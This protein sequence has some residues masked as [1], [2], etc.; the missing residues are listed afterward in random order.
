MKAKRIRGGI[1]VKSC[2]R[3][4]GKKKKYGDHRTWFGLHVRG[5]CLKQPEGRVEYVAWPWDKRRKLTGNHKSGYLFW[6]G[7]CG[8]AWAGK[9][10]VA[11]EKVLGSCG[12][13]WGHFLR[14]MFFSALTGGGEEEDL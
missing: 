11:V 6:R 4:P 7:I 5:R 13:M 12:E 10:H 2:K 9:C 8:L 3:R 1:W 14:I